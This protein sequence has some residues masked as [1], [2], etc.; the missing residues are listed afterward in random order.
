M[1]ANIAGIPQK[2]SR[3]HAVGFFSLELSRMFIMQRLISSQA[4]IASHAIRTG[5]L[6]TADFSNI[7]EAATRIYEAELYIG[8]TPNMKLHELCAEARR[9][10]KQKKVEIIFIDYL[11]LIR[12]EERRND[13]QRREKFTEISMSLNALARELNI[14]LV[15][16]S[17]VGKSSGAPTMA[18]LWESGSIEYADVVM[19]LDRERQ[20]GRKGDEE[21]KQERPFVETLTLSVEKQRNGPTGAVKLT[22]LRQYSRFESYSEMTYNK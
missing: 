21:E 8:D 6:Q 10:H 4:R 1:A 13:M 11:D 20:K 15:V 3:K 14:P 22:F 17:Q 18:D 9:M 7:T 19:I 5:M 16:M 2:S 12:F